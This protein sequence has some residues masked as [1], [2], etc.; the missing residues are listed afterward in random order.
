MKI[1]RKIALDAPQEFI[2]R[3]AQDFCRVSRVKAG[4][5]GPCWTAIMKGK[6]NEHMLL[7]MDSGK[8]MEDAW[9][10]MN[11]K[12]LLG[13]DYR[14]GTPEYNRSSYARAV[15]RMNNGKS[16]T[17]IRMARAGKTRRTKQ[18]KAQTELLKTQPVEKNLG[19]VPQDFVIQPGDKGRIVGFTKGSTTVQVAR[20]GF[21]WYEIPKGFVPTVGNPTIFTDSA[22][23][24]TYK[25]TGELTS[26][27]AK[28]DPLVQ[29]LM[30]DML[31]ESLV[32][33][34]KYLK[35]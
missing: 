25:V 21:F 12:M 3:E 8:N 9:K 17:D 31:L 28:A 24:R 30:E 27:M 18:P 19:A 2:S 5:D 29:R 23:V 1:K 16:W 11:E 14:F 20:K 4:F 34:P 22:G 6:F 10:S 13:P 32:S 15:T 35:G 26:D 33:P 7:I